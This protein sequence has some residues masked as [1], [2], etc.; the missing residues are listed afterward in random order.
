MNSSAEH[1]TTFAGGSGTKLASV[2]LGIVFILVG[3]FAFLAPFVSTLAMSVIVAAAATVAG[4]AHILQA[5]RAAKWKGF[6]LSLLLGIV[7]LAASVAFWLNPLV[8]ALAITMMLSWLLVVAGVGEIALGFRVRPERGW[9]WFVVAG[10]LTV[11]CGIWL[12][13]RLPMAGFLVP[14]V[15]L[16]ITL[17]FEGTAFLAHGLSRSDPVAP[18]GAVPA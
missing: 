12:M 3:T 1:A 7:Y 6:F 4:V 5:F 17:I 18:A 8:T 11:L 9:F 13:F 15:A 2:F 14:G 16:G 10:L